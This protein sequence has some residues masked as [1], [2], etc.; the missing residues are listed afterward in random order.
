MNCLYKFRAMA[1]Q[2]ESATPGYQQNSYKYII[3]RY[4]RIIVV[5]DK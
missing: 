1:A 2:S 3:G 5:C 4:V